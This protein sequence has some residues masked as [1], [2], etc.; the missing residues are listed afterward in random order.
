MPQERPFSGTQAITDMSGNSIWDHILSR[1]E[2][3]VGR[4]SFHTWVKPTSLLKDEGSHVTVLVPNLLFTEWLP[5]HYSGVLAE[6]MNDV[7]RP[8][9]EVIFVPE[10]TS[11][12][13][14]PPPAVVDEALELPPE[15]LP[16]PVT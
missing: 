5:K 3:K 10:G 2:A 13:E 9:V 14:M 1:I 8:E 4:H 15:E 16:S 11:T 6:A 12:T 7:G